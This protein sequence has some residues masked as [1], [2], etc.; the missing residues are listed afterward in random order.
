MFK[1]AFLSLLFSSFA[2]ANVVY[3]FSGQAETFSGITFAF[4]FETVAPDFITADTFNVPTTQCSLQDVPWGGD[5]VTPDCAH[6]IF[7]PQGNLPPLTSVPQIT[8]SNAGSTVG[9]NWFFDLGAFDAPGV[10][11]ATGGWPDRK[12]T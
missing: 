4:S 7:Y 10:Y 2:F 3:S 12:S 5:W 8:L 11:L 6:I 9:Y 1:T